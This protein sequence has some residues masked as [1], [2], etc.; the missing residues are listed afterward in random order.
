MVDWDCFGAPIF[1]P[2]FSDRLAACRSERSQCRSG[3]AGRPRVLSI[4]QLLGA[5]ATDET[6]QDRTVRRLLCVLAVKST[7]PDGKAEERSGGEWK[8]V[9]GRDEVW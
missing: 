9:V 6:R 8:G 5:A 1:W 2:L 3:T 4:I 7:V